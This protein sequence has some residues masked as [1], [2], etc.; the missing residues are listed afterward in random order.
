METEKGKRRGGL[1]FI[2]LPKGKTEDDFKLPCRRRHPGQ[3]DA[4]VQAEDVRPDG[5][6]R[7]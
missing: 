5:R 4:F 1:E 2:P 7:G 6:K 3:L